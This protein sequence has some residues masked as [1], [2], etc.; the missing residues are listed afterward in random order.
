M[1]FWLEELWLSLLFRVVGSGAG[2]GAGGV[3]L[4]GVATP[5]LPPLTGAELGVPGW[6]PP[7][8]VSL[9]VWPPAS[10]TG[11]PDCGGLGDCSMLLAAA[12]DFP[13]L[14]ESP[15]VLGLETD[16]G[17]GGWWLGRNGLPC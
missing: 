16:V 13:P 4:E 1:D 2:L 7:L 17:V 6:E 14:L 9:T 8:C 3:M 12:R 11:V 15:G 5:C 10:P